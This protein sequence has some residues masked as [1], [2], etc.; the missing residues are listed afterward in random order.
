MSAPLPKGLWYEARYERYRV[1]L[2]Q[3]G[4]AYLAG[5]YPTEREARSALRKLQER[6]KTQPRTPGI[7]FRERAFAL[8][9]TL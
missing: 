6:L 9:K 8:R 3:A 2:Y 7:S 1:R 4:R 5:Y